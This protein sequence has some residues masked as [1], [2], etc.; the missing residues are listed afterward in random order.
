LH[1]ALWGF[2]DT[3]ALTPMAHRSRFFAPD[4][5]APELARADVSPVVQAAHA[6]W[7]RLPER[8]PA[9]AELVTAVHRRPEPLAAALAATPATFLPGDWKMGNLGR[10]P[11]GR[12][13]LLDCAYPGEGP[14]CWDLA[15]YLAL[16]RSRLPISKEETIR[17]YRDELARAG[18]DVAGWFD[19]QM[20]LCLL[21]IAATFGWEKALGDDAELAWW[22]DRALAA[23]RLLP[24]GWRTA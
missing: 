16:N 9:L 5:I 13:I 10:H 6:G 22:A 2:R 11:D 21:S 1:A 8:S 3:L 4:V 7:G 24:V 20:A 17:W 19:R 18:I 23:E 14:G 15:W 12:T